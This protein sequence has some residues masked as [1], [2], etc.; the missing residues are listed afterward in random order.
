MLAAVAWGL[1]HAALAAIY[2]TAPDLSGPLD[3]A[4]IM[5]D[6]GAAYV[7]PVPFEVSF[8]YWIR[9]D[10]PLAGFDSRLRLR[11]DGKPLGPAHSLHVDIRQFGGGR[12]SHWDG[13]IWFSA[14]DSS[15]PRTNGRTYS[16]STTASVHPAL[17]MFVLFVDLLVVLALHRQL[18][19]F[20]RRRSG[21]LLNTAI[22]VPVLFAALAA[23]G[24]LGRINAAAG[25][26]KDAALVAATLAHAMLGSA[27]LAG[28]WLAGAG[29]V[30]LLL[31]KRA[32]LSDLLLLGFPLGMLAAAILAAIALA[33]P[34]GMIIAALA[35]VACTS[36]L[37]GWRPA[38]GEMRSLLRVCLLAL[39]FAVAFGSWLA[40]LWHGPTETLAGSPSG[41]L[42]Y[43]ATSIPQLSS[44]PY[45]YLNLGYERL[46]FGSYDRLLFPAMGAVLTRVVPVD[47]F[48]FILAAGGSFFVLSLAIALHAFAT[49]VRASDPAR[50]TVLPT[51]ILW[52]AVIVANRYPYWVAE[53]VPVIYTAP[54]TIAVLHW[55][56]RPQ[57]R[58]RFRALA[59]AIIGS[60]L[61]K[62]AG[63]TVLGPFA[64]AAAAP[65]FWR[66]SRAGRLIATGAAAA[67]A[68][69]AA[70]LLA[71]HG[72]LYF[73]IAPFGPTSLTWIRVHGVPLVAIIP[74][75]LRDVAA[76]L[77]SL[78]AFLIAPPLIA[79]AIGLGFLIFLAHP[80]TFNVNFVCGTLIV[81]LLA[82]E[83]AAGLGRYRTIVLTA[84]AL[85][86]PAAL[87]TDPAGWSSGVAWAV[88]V[89]GAAAVGLAAPVRF[90][91]ARGSGDAFARGAGGA[92]I[93]LCL[94]LLA[95]GR[96][97]IVVDSGWRAGPPELTP[98]VREVWLA[99]KAL[100]P[101]DALIFTDQTSIEPR[102]LGGWNTYVAI[103]ERQ[104]FVSNL[105]MN[106]ATRLNQE[107]AASDLRENES[108]LNGSL[109]PDQLTLR[110]DYSRYFAVVSAGRRVPPAW[111]GL[112]ANRDYALYEIPG[113]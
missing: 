77:L 12:F 106:E 55:A 78:S 11:E 39:P 16:A 1:L 7:T 62:T 105:L 111:R 4:A 26:P 71:R 15:D 33:A 47:P 45:P 93:A 31:G 61:S 81:G 19:N 96:G 42:V 24:V 60:A 3:A 94:A 88:C 8:P 17:A 53:S 85:A 95:V 109:H 10:R 40:L 57:M 14:L 38:Q 63:A 29:V 37:L 21:L 9:N 103:G 89:G 104:V 87:L 50:A 27:I 28:H 56:R 44:R 76:V 107:R 83:R 97:N 70:A 108:V 54:L 41:D 74:L 67:S 72:P 43:Y 25:A 84:F 100:T 91:A 99:A 48:L 98:Q 80:F 34:N 112:F 64:I 18:A 90:P 110:S 5:P 23:A 2:A 36:G 32:A 49:G 68:V 20:V 102:L 22:G 6:S 65:R 92:A 13:A 52:L 58:A 75:L 59:F 30:R 51:G 79:A 86:L 69:Y 82:Y 35:W 101:P 73:A 113:S 46:P 66:L